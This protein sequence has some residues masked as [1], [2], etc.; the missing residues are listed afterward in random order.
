MK[1]LI[2]MIVLPIM[3]CTS[4]QEK[5]D[6]LHAIAIVCNER[7]KIPVI[8]NGIVKTENGKI[9]LRT[10]KENCKEEWVAWNKAEEHIIDVE[11]RRAARQG[12]ICPSGQIAI[13][14]NFCMKDKPSERVWGCAKQ[15]I[16]HGMIP[17]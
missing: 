1:Y 4:M 15:L 9:V 16:F 7:E 2:L 11:I 17:Y 14:D 3:A 13:C 5:A 10:P 6:E 8:E 12:P